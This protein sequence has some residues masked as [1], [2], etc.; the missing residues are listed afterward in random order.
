MSQQPGILSGCHDRHLCN[1]GNCS[2]DRSG[3]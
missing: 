3:R 2:G 1:M